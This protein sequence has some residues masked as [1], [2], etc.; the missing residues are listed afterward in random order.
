MSYQFS[1]TIIVLTKK[2]IA[3]FTSQQKKEYLEAMEIPEGYQG[4][5]LLTVLRDPK[6]DPPEYLKFVESAY[7]KD[8]KIKGP[9]GTFA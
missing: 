9:I 1:E 4:P 8:A 2:N 5:K 6:V 7:G 3:V